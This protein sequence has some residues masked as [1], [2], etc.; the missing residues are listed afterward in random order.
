MLLCAHDFIKILIACFLGGIIGY[1]RQKKGMSMGMRTHIIVCISATLVQIISIDY[2]IINKSNT[3]V[4][5]LGA[6]V[7]SGIGFLGMASIIKEGGNVVGLTTAASVWFI[8]CVG[9]AVGTGIYVPAVIATLVVYFILRDIFKIDKRVKK[10]K[11][12]ENIYEVEIILNGIIANDNEINSIF[13]IIMKAKFK[14]SEIRVNTEDKSNLM[15]YM[16]IM[17]PSNKEPNSILG[18]LLQYEYVK[19]V[20]IL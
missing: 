3:D 20:N 16:N 6:Q 9:L 11:G 4:M 15:I 5:R 1:Q 17:V 19:R 7:I 14:I 8:A 13:K 12:N 2:N 10:V 18:S